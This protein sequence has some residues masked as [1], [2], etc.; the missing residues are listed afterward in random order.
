MLHI[1]EA[2]G[3]KVRGEGGIMMEAEIGVMCSEDEGKG[4]KARHID[5]LYKLEKARVIMLF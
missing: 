4:D 3:T 5:D 1:R 2:G